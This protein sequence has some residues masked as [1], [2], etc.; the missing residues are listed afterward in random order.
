MDQKQFDKL[1]KVN[2][3]KNLGYRTNRLEFDPNDLENAFSQHWQKENKK[4]A[5]INFG[6]GI[7]QDLFFERDKQYSPLPTWDVVTCL[8]KVTK[9][10]RLIVATVIQWLGS[11]CGFCWLNEALN[12]AGYKIVKKK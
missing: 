3:S 12:K 1:I 7:L 9:M 6:H 8:H 4:Q 5:H 10:E 2:G 11:N